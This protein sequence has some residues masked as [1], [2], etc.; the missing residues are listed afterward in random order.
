MI[1]RADV[2]ER[3]SEP[4]ADRADRQLEEDRN[5][6]NRTM[7]ALME[8]HH[9]VQSDAASRGWLMVGQ[10]IVRGADNDIL[11]FAI[12]RDGMIVSECGFSIGP[13]K[14]VSFSR[15]AHREITGTLDT[16]RE[17]E[18]HSLLAAWVSDVHAGIGHRW[19][20]EAKLR[21]QGG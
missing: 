15:P 4:P 17:T 21:G 16:I 13:G 20:Y 2:V 14:A 12:L 18:F 7:A 9:R 10:P 3:Q 19:T 8:A 1:R 11:R 5:A 6:R